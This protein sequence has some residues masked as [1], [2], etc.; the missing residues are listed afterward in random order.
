MLYPGRIERRGYELVLWQPKDLALGPAQPFMNSVCTELLNAIKL[1]L[2]KPQSVA[3]KANFT[4]V[5]D[6]QWKKKKMGI[7]CLVQYQ[8]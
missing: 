5:R 3:N 7:N 1:Q 6:I 2:P 4:G 8:S